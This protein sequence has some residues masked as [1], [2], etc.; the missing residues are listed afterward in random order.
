MRYPF[1][2]KSNASLE[3][4]QFWSIPLSDGRFA[5]G[6]VVRIDRELSFGRRTLFVAGVLDWIGSAEPT[7]ES[8]AGARLLDVGYAHVRAI[9]DDGGAVLGLRPLESD[10]LEVPTSIRSHWSPSFPRLRAERRFIE[11]DP[12]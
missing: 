5:C 8:I 9:T 7:S 11:G 12:P 10:S 4:G 1:T 3:P 6:R 2:P